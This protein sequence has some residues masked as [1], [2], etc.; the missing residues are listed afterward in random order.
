MASQLD[1]GFGSYANA[2]A[3]VL[4]AFT[5]VK[6]GAS[7][8]DLTS[9]GGADFFGVAQEDIAIGGKGLVKLCSA[10]GTV[11]LRTGVATVAGTTYSLDAT[12]V[13]V[14]IATAP[15]DVARVRAVLS[16]SSGDVNEFI[17]V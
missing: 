9:N 11:M 3:A 17:I 10:D 14:A 6:I 1:S 8:V 15:R 12:G 16:A 7:G 4:P 2:N 13:V 5:A